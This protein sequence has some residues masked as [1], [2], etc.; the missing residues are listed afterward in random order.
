MSRNPSEFPPHVPTTIEVGA[1][2]L[3]M[4]NVMV[5]PEGEQDRLVSLLQQGMINEMSK[6][7]GFLSSNIHRSLDSNIVLVYAQWENV[8]AL[9]A[10]GQVVAAGN[11]PNMAQAYELGKAEYHPYEVVSIH[12][13]Q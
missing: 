1:D 10:A 2:F 5:A 9:Q 6:Q 4:I 12:N 7:P 11:A 13:P 8:E 3:T